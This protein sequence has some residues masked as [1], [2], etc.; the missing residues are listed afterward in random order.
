MKR[1]ENTTENL[2]KQYDKELKA[3]LAYDLKQ[4][5]SANGKFLSTKPGRNQDNALLVA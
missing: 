1:N 3:I 2:L 5:K 4:F